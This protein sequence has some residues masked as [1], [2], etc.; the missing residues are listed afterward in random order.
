MKRNLEIAALAIALLVGFNPAFAGQAPGAADAAD[1]PINEPLAAIDPPSIRFD[2]DS[3]QRS[4]GLK[5]IRIKSGAT[6]IKV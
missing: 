1:V 2:A 4:N 5:N 3:F 6:G